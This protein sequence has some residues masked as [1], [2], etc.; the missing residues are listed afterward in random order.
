MERYR[1]P[2]SFT[3]AALSIG[4]PRPLR[5]HGLDESTTASNTPAVRQHALPR[6]GRVHPSGTPMFGARQELPVNE[7]GIIQPPEGLDNPEVSEQP[8]P[9]IPD[10]HASGQ[11]ERGFMSSLRSGL[12]RV[13][14]TMEKHHSRQSL[15]EEYVAEAQ[16]ASLRN[17]Q[18]S[19][20][21]NLNPRTYLFEI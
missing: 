5:P 10:M 19:P 16:A 1:S 21:M 7:L 18:M 8:T 2:Q 13:A 6:R 9:I 17:S 3:S 15:Y 20:N 12:R 4:T 11:P 14:K